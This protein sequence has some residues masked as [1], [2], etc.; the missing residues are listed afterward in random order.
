MGFKVL[1]L[2][3]FPTPPQYECILKLFNALGWRIDCIEVGFQDLRMLSAFVGNTVIVSPEVDRPKIVPGEGFLRVLLPVNCDSWEE[4]VELLRGETFLYRTVN[5]AGD[6]LIKSGCRVLETEAEKIFVCEGEREVSELFYTQP[7]EAEVGKLL[8]EKGLTISTAESCTG[9]LVAATLV[10]VAGSSEYFMGSVVAYD[11]AVKERVLGVGA[12]TLEKYG[13]VSA[14]TAKEMAE[15]VRKLLGTDLA[16]ST[17]GIAG[18]GGGTPEKPVGL[19]YFALAT[20]EGTKVFKKVF[21]Y[22]RNQNRRAA[23]YFILFELYKY[24]KGIKNPV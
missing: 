13:A 7:L 19:T 10:N 8:R 6:E 20:P 17:T 16:L 1:F 2:K 9:G 15:G 3:T 4:V 12:Q 23:T 14:E 21:P 5:G 22:G 18:P 24:L 11:N